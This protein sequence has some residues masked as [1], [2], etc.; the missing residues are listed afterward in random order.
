MIL[1]DKDIKEYISKKELIIEHA[2]FENINSIS[3]DI[4]LNSFPNQT[5]KTYLLKPNE[6]IIIQTYEKISLPENIMAKVEEK[7][8][9]LR[10]GLVVNGPCYQPGHE[11]YCYLRVQNISDK[12]ILLNQGLKI[13]QLVFIKLE[14]IPETPY[15]LQK[16]A[17]FQKEEKY[18]KYGNYETIYNKMIQKEK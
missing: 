13:A 17:S 11:T 14:N 9:L 18:R 8:S 10:M 4:T 12:P 16:N 1:V 6:F 15:N 7:N 5:N 3:Y 2:N